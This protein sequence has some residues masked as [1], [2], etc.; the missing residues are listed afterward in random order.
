MYFL[1][2]FI[3]LISFTLFGT[4]AYI[5]QSKHIQLIAQSLFSEIF[6]LTILCFLQDHSYTLP[7]S[8]DDVRAP[9]IDPLASQKSL[10]SEKRNEMAREKRVKNTV[11]SLQ[12]HLRRMT[13]ITVNLKDKIYSCS[14]N[15]QIQICRKSTIR[16]FCLFRVPSYFKCFS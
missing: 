4:W 7:S 16:F 2:E 11:H 13:L 8:S 14:R 1:A 15:I 5:H 6:C 3:H 12:E 10:K 9:F